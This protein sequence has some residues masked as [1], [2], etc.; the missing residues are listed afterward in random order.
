VKPIPVSAL[1]ADEESDADDDSDE[2]DEQAA[3]STRHIPIAEI[4]P[5]LR[6]MVTCGLARR[7]AECPT[8]PSLL[9]DQRCGD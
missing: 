7:P 3:T 9:Q 4:D 5:S 8:E 1:G 6:I 2:P